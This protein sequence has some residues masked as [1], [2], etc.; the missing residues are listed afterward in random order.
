MATGYGDDYGETLSGHGDPELTMATVEG[1][2]V[3]ADDGG[4]VVTL[5]GSFPRKTYAIQVNGEACYGGQSGEGSRCHPEGD[6]LRFVVPAGLALGPADLRLVSADG[7]V[8]LP[9]G[10]TVVRRHRRL[11]TYHLNELA[12][13]LGPHPARGPVLPDGDAIDAPGAVYGPRRATL[14]AIGQ[15]FN[16]IGGRLLTRLTAEAPAGALAPPSAEAFT[17]GGGGGGGGGGSIVSSPFLQ[18]ESTFGFPTAGTLY[19]DGELVRYTGTTPTKFTG[20]TRDPFR[21]TPQRAGEVVAL[22][23]AANGPAYS[24]IEATRDALFVDTATGLSLDILGRNYGVNR[25]EGAN[26]DLYRALIRLLSY[27]PGRGTRAA[28]AAFLDLVTQDCRITLQGAAYD[29]AAATL[30]VPGATFGPT[31]R[32][33]RIRLYAGAAGVGKPVATLM[34]LGPLDAETLAVDRRS[35]QAHQAAATAPSGTYDAQ[36]VPYDILEPAARPGVVVIRMRCPAPDIEGL[37]YLHAE[38]LV[39]STDATTVEVEHPSRQVVGVWLTTDPRREG[40]NYATNNDF[41]GSTIT[42]E[43]ALP[44]A[45]TEVLVAYGLIAT[46]PEA[47]TPG[48]PGAATGP[49]TAHLFLNA[50]ERADGS[51]YPAYLGP[52]EQEVAALLADLTVGGVIGEVEERWT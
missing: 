7:T 26:D 43:S 37:T 28:I 13:P 50:T 48:L 15:L 41:D 23:R 33:L 40:T 24:A 9:G 4:Q 34:V 1:A 29:A 10:L 6:A 49:G 3:V 21:A 12:S 11:Q 18:V 39:T 51:R 47:P 14:D 16:E 36:T 22:H 46:P 32:Q 35:G 2:G 38:E 25:P 19:L 42:M 8:E 17:G 20:L 30:T 44:G 45:A 27:Q 52:R 5:G 31:W